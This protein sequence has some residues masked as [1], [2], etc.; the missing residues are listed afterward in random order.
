MLKKADVRASKNREVDNLKLRLAPFVF[1][2]WTEAQKLSATA[3]VAQDQ[4]KQRQEAEK[5]QLRELRLSLMEKEKRLKQLT[6]TKELAPPKEFMKG[7]K[8]AVKKKQQS[9][10]YVAG[11]EKEF[12]DVESE[13]QFFV[14][15]LPAVRKRRKA[16]MTLVKYYE[17]QMAGLSAGEP[18]V[19]AAESRHADA[20]DLLAHEQA[21]LAEVKAD[22]Q[23]L[24]EEHEQLTFAIDEFREAEEAVFDAG[25]FDQKEFTLITKPPTQK[26]F[27]RYRKDVIRLIRELVE[28]GVKGDSLETIF[29]SVFQSIDWSVQGF[30]SRNDIKIICKEGDK[31]S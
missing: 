5:T 23:L 12:R 15:E 22:K 2:P 21:Q 17:K 1:K 8:A 24:R 13:L 26:K 10:E 3:Q 31:E 29:E 19:V 16:K 28:T 9:A 6:E 11:F 25:E 30:P 4:R 14:K 20:K 27:L 18:K 7:V